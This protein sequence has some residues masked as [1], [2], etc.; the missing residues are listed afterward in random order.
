VEF[1]ARDLAY[2]H[3]LRVI[4]VVK[5]T[6]ETVMHDITTEAQWLPSQQESDALD[7]L[8]CPYGVGGT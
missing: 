1:Y 6:N 8:T 7:C 4:A 5:L 3:S 2:H